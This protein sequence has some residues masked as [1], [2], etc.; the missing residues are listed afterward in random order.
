MQFSR[1]HRN[2]CVLA[3]CQALYYVG[4]SIMFILGGLVGADLAENKALSTLP[5]TVIIIATALSTIPASLIMRRIGRKFGFMLGATIAMIGSCIASYGIYQSSFWLFVT[6]TM[7]IGINGGF[8]QYF[9][10]AAADV[11]EANFKSKAISLVISGGIIAAFIGP[12]LVNY[13]FDIYVV[14]FFGSFISIL[15]LASFAILTLS[16]LDIPRPDL[17][18]R[19]TSGR[20]LWIVAQN[21]ELLGAIFVGMVGYGMMSLLMTATPLAMVAHGYM[22]HD[23]SFVI[24]WHLVAM[25]GPALFTG[26]LINRLGVMRVMMIGALLLFLSILT[27]LTGETVTYFWTALFAL[28]LGW[29]FTFIGASFLLTETYLPKERAKIQALNDFMVFGF[30]ALCS[31]TSGTLFHYFD[32]HTINQVAIPIIVI[33]SFV[34][35]GLMWRRNRLAH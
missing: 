30:V 15:F 20:P 16:F 7:T 19:A 12:I 10:F 26:S 31:L 9:R 23:A 6:G 33:A 4:Q 18:E 22:V 13:T 1:D 32:W 34:I 24:Q 25:F 28:G 35:A 14:P 27:A 21:P 2:V 3:L 5:I 17:R 11:A 8:A 29:N